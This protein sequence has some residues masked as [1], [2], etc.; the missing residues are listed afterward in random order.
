MIGIYKITNRINNKVYIGQSTNIQKRWINH[1]STSRNPNE[2]GYNYPLYQAMRKYGI[3]NFT[4]EI[5]EECTQQ[6][7]N[8]REKYWIQYY[9]AYGDGG[10]N[11]KEGGYSAVWHKISPEMLED[12]T[13]RLIRG[14]SQVS[15]CNLYNLDKTTVNQINSGKMWYREK[16][17]YPLQYSKFGNQTGLKNYSN[18]TF[19]IDCGI[20][21]SKGSTRCVVCDLK[22]RH[23]NSPILE[24]FSTMQ[25]VVLL[26]KK[27]LLTSYVAVSREYGVSDNSVRKWLKYFELPVDK[28]EL[29]QWLREHLTEDEW[30]SIQDKLPKEKQTQQPCIKYK[31]YQLDKDGNILNTFN[32]PIE[33]ARYLGDESYRTHIA[34]VCRG[35]RKTA[36][37]YYWEYREE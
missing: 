10:Y 1:Q 32:S 24:R 9:N 29:K 3:D 11:Q 34:E 36:Y 6:Q 18:K 35:V 20:E 31:V 12:I 13:E 7:L 15:I 16:L 33:A 2:A 23:E 8:E 14:E 25:D 21:I 30:L 17:Q 22:R 28:L 19:C 27:V 4:F 5:L 37:K 26:V